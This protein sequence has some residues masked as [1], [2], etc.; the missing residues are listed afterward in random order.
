MKAAIDRIDEGVSILL[1][2]D[3]PPHRITLPAALLPPGSREGDI[4]DLR[5]GR[6]EAATDTAR[7]RAAGQIRRL[8]DRS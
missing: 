7:A 5:L 3:L 4:L 6:D 8:Q 1:T 2:D